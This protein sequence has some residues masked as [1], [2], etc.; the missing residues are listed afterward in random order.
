MNHDQLAVG[1]AVHVQFDAVGA[2]VEGSGKGGQ[3]VFR[4]DAPC[5][6]MGKNLG[7]CAT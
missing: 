3:G 6:A 5:A 7:S 4:G 1:R 2:H